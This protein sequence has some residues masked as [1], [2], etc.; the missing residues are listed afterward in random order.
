MFFKKRPRW[1]SEENWRKWLWRRD[2]GKQLRRQVGR[3][4]VNPKLGSAYSAYRRAIRT[5]DWELV[6]ERVQVVAAL[7]DSCGHWI[8]VKE[9]IS[10]WSQLGDYEESQRLWLNRLNRMPKTFPNEWQ[11]EDLTGKNVLVQL[12]P[13]NRQGLSVGYRRARLMGR[14]IEPAR[15]VAVNVESRLVETFR[16]SF[17][18]IEMW[19]STADLNGDEFDFV[20]LPDRMM[21]HFLPTTIEPNK[22]GDFLVPDQA[23]VKQLRKKY[24]ADSRCRGSKQLIGVC[25]HSSHFAKDSPSLEHW[26]GLMGR[27]DAGFVS[28]QYGDVDSHISVL[29]RG[30]IIVDE[31][32]DQLVDMDVFAA[33][34]AALDG[35]ITIVNTLAHVGGAL[36]VPTVVVRDDMLRREWPVTSDRTPWYPQVRIAGKDGRNWD[37]VLDEAWGKLR[38][39]TGVPR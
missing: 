7:A 22:P 13:S 9:M 33:Q 27:V 6:R 31:A 8:T 26:A 15:R 18:S 38:E 29:G 19:D 28:L 2:R 25:W 34:V 35:V 16:R 24:L 5:R 21:A 30:N 1:I 39:M 36:N 11:G 12:H 10:A 20:I 23:L 4:L 3:Y 37:E 17:P 32:V 14:V